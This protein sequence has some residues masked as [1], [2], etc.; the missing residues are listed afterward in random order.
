M[1]WTTLLVGIPSLVLAASLVESRNDSPS[2]SWSD[3]YNETISLRCA[4]F[5][6]PVDW[7]NPEGEHFDLF[8][9]KLPARDAST[10]IGNLFFSPGGPGEPPSDI[11]V[12][13]TSDL[14]LFLQ[15]RSV[16][17]FDL[18]A[19]DPR[20]AGRSNPVCC[21]P[22]LWNDLPSLF[23]ESKAACDEM[24]AYWKMI[25]QDCLERTGPFLQFVDTMIAVKDFEAVRIVLG[26]EPMK[27][28][29]TSYGSQFGA[30]DAEVF[31]DN[32]RAMVLDGVL[33]HTQSRP[34]YNLETES[35]AFENGLNQFF[36]WCKSE[37]A[38]ALHDET[39]I[40]AYFD[41]LIDRANAEPFQLDPQYCRDKRCKGP[42]NGYDI[43]VKALDFISFPN[44][45]HGSPGFV[46][47]SKMLKNASEHGRVEPFA[48]HVFTSD[49]DFA[50]SYTAITCADWT[51]SQENTTYAQYR[52][53][54]NLAKT[55]SPHT[56]G[57]G[58][59]WATKTSCQ[60]WPVPPRNLPHDITTLKD[61]GKKLATP[62]LMVNAFYDP[63]TSYAWAVNLQR[64]L[65]DENAVL[66]S[67]NGI[68]HTSFAQHGAVSDAIDEYLIN[69]VVPEAGTVLQNDGL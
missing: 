59:V 17:F 24:V 40:P 47:Y 46:G 25:G 8:I 50:Y 12:P 55:A 65:G 10:R 44:G 38:C 43:A 18:I 27:F 69:L 4:N 6:V 3:C 60:S 54:M 7:D 62:I 34:V 28:I 61:S 2:I 37:S 5:S 42:L 66:L 14:D 53:L 57:G 31:P 68:G 49:A 41:R 15:K 22:R 58:E 33:D 45:E 52:N 13:G 35:G 19:I 11:L 16:P 67:R 26:A 1:I 23:P 32:I 36:K 39:D 9:T 56:R 30:Q 63:A 64:Q 20:G 29:G 48:R 51:F 21:D